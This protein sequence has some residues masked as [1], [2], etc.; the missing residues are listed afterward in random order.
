MGGEV[1]TYRTAASTAVMRS[2][3]HFAQLTVLGGC[4]DID[5]IRPGWEVEGEEN[6]EQGNRIDML[7][8]DQGSMTI[9]KNDGK[10]GV[11]QAEGLSGPLCWAVVCG[12][13]DS[14]RIESAPAFASPT[15]EERRRR[16]RGSSRIMTPTTNESNELAGGKIHGYD[17][18]EPKKER[19]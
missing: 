13:G 5:V 9:W 11:M 17:S 14:V 1:D 10:L 15:E 16:R 2:G 19:R 4:L 18:V 12:K 3:R 8:L 6:A 7:D